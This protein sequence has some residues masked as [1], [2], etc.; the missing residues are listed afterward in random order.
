MTW[1]LFV[2]S[3]AGAHAP[4]CTVTA[5]FLA[6]WAV[7]VGDRL[8]DADALPCLES[9][10]RGE[11]QRFFVGRPQTDLELRHHFHHH[12]RRAFWIILAALGSAL[13]CLLPHLPARTLLAESMLAILLAGWLLRVHRAAHSRHGQ[14]LPKEFVV[15]LFFALAIY[16]PYT[17]Q[18]KDESSL[19]P[20]ALLFA[21]LCTLNCLFLYAWEH[22]HSLSRAHPA[23]AFA[24]R[25]LVPFAFVALLASLFVYYTSRT[26]TLGQVPEAC[27]LSLSLLL[28]LHAN[29]QRFG[30]LRLRALADLVLLS[31]VS[32]VLGRYLG[33]FHRVAA[34][35]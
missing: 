32:V 30:S 26:A 4:L 20:G 1:L 2:G 12:Y 25:L 24:V 10:P 5:L 33:L 6:V 21:G 35:L 27:A 13:A 3:C 29:R 31:P 17:D 22:P 34:H 28:V 7:Y 11:S 18:I 23:T 9:T 8:L 16:L 19:L 15:G 14:R